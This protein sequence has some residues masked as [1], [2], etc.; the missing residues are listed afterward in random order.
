M[1]VS[2][3]DIIWV[4][5]MVLIAICMAIGTCGYILDVVLGVFP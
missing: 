2:K 3:L 1:K 5:G 4:V